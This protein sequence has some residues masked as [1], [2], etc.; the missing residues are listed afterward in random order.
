MESFYRLEHNASIVSWIFWQWVIWMQ[1]IKG[2]R[3]INWKS[4]QFQYIYPWKSVMFT[5]FGIVK[6]DQ[7]FMHYPHSNLE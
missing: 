6:K 1:Y 7:Q 2:I 4:F 5:I 3:N